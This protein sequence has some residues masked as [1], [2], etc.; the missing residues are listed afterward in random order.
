MQKIGKYSQ[1]INDKS[2]GMLFFGREKDSYLINATFPVSNK[3]KEIIAKMLTELKKANKDELDQIYKTQLM[4]SS[5]E[6]RKASGFGFTQL[7]KIGKSWD[8]AFDH[9][10]GM[11]SELVY[12]IYI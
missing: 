2:T 5:R 11:L 6:E 12:Q 1:K 9:P 8:F 7:A 4:L 3:N 10:E